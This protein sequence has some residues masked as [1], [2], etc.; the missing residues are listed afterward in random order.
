MA[1]AT[2][3]TV[4]VWGGTDRETAGAANAAPSPAVAPPGEAVVAESP[5]ATSVWCA[6]SFADGRSVGRG[7]GSI[8][9]GPGVIRAFD[10]AYYVE[11]DGGR[12]ASL[13][14]APNPVPEIQ[15]WIDEVPLGTEHC[16]TITATPEPNVYTVDLGLRMPA[17]SE[18]VIRQRITVAPAPTGFRIA[19]VEDLR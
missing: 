14:V 12:V 8:A 1:I 17:G 19:K 3:A 4:L 2:A 13:M 15:K 7:S 16:V 10:H 9:D 6:D 5:A 11:R 18:G